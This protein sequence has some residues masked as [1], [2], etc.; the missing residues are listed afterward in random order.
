METLAISLLLHGNGY[1]QILPD[2]H[3]AP[4][5]LFALRPERVSIEADPRG[6]PMAYRYRAGEVTSLLSA[7]SVI[8]IRVHHPLDDHYGLGC[9]D[10]RPPLS[11]PR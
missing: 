11:G 3:G 4:A 10:D 2:T 8:H 6:W 5:E 9:L 7:D 1:V